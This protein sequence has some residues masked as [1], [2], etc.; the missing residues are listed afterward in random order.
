MIDPRHAELAKVLVNYSCEVKKGQN[1]L[2]EAY[3]TPVEFLQSL[4]TA[5]YKAGG[6]PTL[7][8]KYNKLLRT[9]LS[10]ATKKSLA[11]MQSTELHRMRKMDAFIGV[12]GLANTKELADL[13]DEKNQLFATEI[14][15][16][17]HAEV[18]VTKTNWVVLRYPTESMA[19]MAGMSTEA[20]EKYYY[21]V[22]AGVDYRKMSKAMGPAQ[23]FMTKADK[24]HIKGPGTDLTFSIK[25]I[26]AVK[27]DGHR[28]IPDGEVYSCPVKTSVNGVITYNS[29]S[30]YNGF[31]FKDVRFEFKNGKIVKATANDTRRINK[32]LDTDAGARYVGE[33]ALGCNP[34]ITFPMD[35]I[36]FDEKIMGSFH[37]TP[38]N[39]YDDTDNSN[40][41]AVHWDL[42][43]IQTKQAGGG[44]IWIDGKLIRKNGVFVHPSFKGLNP[45]NLKK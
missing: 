27:C 6:Y 35:E 1:V 29:P 36:L 2:I 44:E 25:G 23:K 8:I 12:R 5:V 37:F 30:T 40:R 31:T 26:G 43:N 17:V 11:A 7:E 41:S 20:F 32:L 39:A 28:N 45:E 38:G 13:A 9:L 4:V 14:F 42:V 22:T 16:K 24:V 34:Y 21:N 3:D 10:K 19:M 33:F 18:R 15:K